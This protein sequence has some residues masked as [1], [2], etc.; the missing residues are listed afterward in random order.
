MLLLAAIHSRTVALVA[1]AL[2]AGCTAISMTLLST[3]LGAMLGRP[4]A[5]RAFGRIVPAFGAF[6]L[7][8]GIWYALGA[9][10]LVP[11]VF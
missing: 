7:C 1:L 9:L 6:G 11:Y 2:F 3:G 8:F 4:R 5:R 10:A